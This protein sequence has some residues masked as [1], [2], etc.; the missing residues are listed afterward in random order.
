MSRVTQWLRPKRHPVPYSALL[1]TRAR[2]IGWHLGRSQN[3]SYSGYH[4]L[5]KGRER[6]RAESNSNSTMYHPN[7]IK[8]KSINN[9]PCTC[10]FLLALTLVITSLFTTV[11][12]GCI[13]LAMLN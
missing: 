2:R 3:D 4:H 6:E 9:N 5:R 1:L 13:T 12:C 7:K 8:I 11:I 10:L